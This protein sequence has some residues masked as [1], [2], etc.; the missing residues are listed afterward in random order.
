M[1]KRGVPEPHVFDGSERGEIRCYAKGTEQEYEKIKHELEMM[2]QE[3]VC[4]TDIETKH[5]RPYAK[6]AMILTA[7]VTTSKR[8]TIAFPIAKP[9]AWTIR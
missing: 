6:G 8:G 1:I 2:Q 5:L 4:A 9:G 3:K 7:A